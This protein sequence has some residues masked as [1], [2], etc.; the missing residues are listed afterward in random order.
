MIFGGEWAQAGQK[1]LRAESGFQGWLT[2]L[3]A[4]RAWGDGD[5][6]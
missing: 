3:T 4:S 2:T 5:S 1:E 6:D